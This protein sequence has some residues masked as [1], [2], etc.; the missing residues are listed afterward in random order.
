MINFE[1]WICDGCGNI[2]DRTELVDSI[3][4]PY[5]HVK[6]G[7]SFKKRYGRNK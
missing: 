2:F 1:E 7:S 5:M 4:L 6:I 3:Q